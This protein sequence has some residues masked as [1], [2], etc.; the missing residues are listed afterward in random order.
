MK[1]KTFVTIIIVLSV[2]GVTAGCGS[3]TTVNTKDGAVTIQDNNVKV[4]TKD[5]KSEITVGKEGEVSLPD[6]YPAETVPIITGGKVS[7]AMK[8]EDQDKKLTFFVTVTSDKDPKEIKQ[9]YQNALQGATDTTSTETPEGFFTTG[10]KG[11]NVYS[12][13]ISTD[14]S[15]S[16]QQTIIQIV[17][18][19]KS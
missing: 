19:P 17:V 8:N 2:L 5:G 7:A 13:T 12:V 1:L 6:G 3:G 4:Q 18:A 14:P 16:K 10:T 11:D 15:N 9:F